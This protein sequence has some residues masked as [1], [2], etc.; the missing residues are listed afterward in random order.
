MFDKYRYIILQSIYVGYINFN[1][2][3]ETS[4]DTLRYSLD[5]SKTFVKWELPNEPLFLQNLPSYEGPYTWGEITLILSGPEW[6]TS[7]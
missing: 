5:L 1:E 3:K 4:S 7:E 6:E 2:V